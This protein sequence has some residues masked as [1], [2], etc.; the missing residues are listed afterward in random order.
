MSATATPAP[1]AGRRWREFRC[2]GCGYRIAIA[3]PHP[4]CPMCGRGSWSPLTTA[5]NLATST[6]NNSQYGRA[7]AH[8]VRPAQPASAASTPICTA[9]AQTAR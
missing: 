9:N 2:E 1:L 7:Q 8:R 5:R 6:A 4:S 3:E